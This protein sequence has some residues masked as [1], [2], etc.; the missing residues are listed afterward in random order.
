MWTL[1]FGQMSVQGIHILMRFSST[2]ILL[3]GQALTQELWSTTKLSEKQVSVSVSVQCRRLLFV[4]Q[5]HMVQYVTLG[6]CSQKK[7]KKSLLFNLSD[8]CCPDCT[9][10]KGNLHV[11]KF[12]MPGLS[13]YIILTFKH[14]LFG[15]I[16]NNPM[17]KLVT[18]NWKVK[19]HTLVSGFVI[20]MLN[21]CNNHDE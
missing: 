16:W 12:Y 11:L 5:E 3:L 21:E 15:P 18:G 7:K 1:P 4:T 6:V 10:T 8:R 14:L 17:K 20:K 13:Y 2:S 19:M 9:L